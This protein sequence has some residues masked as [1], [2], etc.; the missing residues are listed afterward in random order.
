M[1]DG[2]EDQNDA[3]IDEW[4]DRNPA[5][6]VPVWHMHESIDRLARL[7]EQWERVCLGSSGVH[8][9]VGTRSWWERMCSA[10]D[11]AC[12]SHG[13][14]HAKLH[15]LRMLDPAVF[16]RLPLSSADSTNAVR[17]SSNYGRFGQYVPPNAST[18]MHI[19][20]ERIET[21]QSAAVWRRPKTQLLIF[22]IELPEHLRGGE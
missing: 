19:I 15:G 4:C 7:V 11:A 18:R 13:R 6:G 14:P 2:D 12:D 10:M 16:H 17:N 20:A 21:H 1:I 22:D 8:A 5:T 3:L 9:T